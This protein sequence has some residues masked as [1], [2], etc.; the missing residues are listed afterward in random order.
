MSKEKDRKKIQT[1]KTFFFIFV[2]CRR[3]HTCQETTL[4]S[5]VLKGARGIPLYPFPPG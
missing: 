4:L 3:F 1:F 2:S 5:F